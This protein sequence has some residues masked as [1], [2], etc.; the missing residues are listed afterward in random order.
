MGKLSNSIQN[1]LEFFSD[2]NYE[3]LT[4]IGLLKHSPKPPTQ[5]SESAA[6]CVTKAMEIPKNVIYPFLPSK[7]TENKMLLDKPQHTSWN[8]PA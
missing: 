5:T 2:R 3:L 8:A 1:H 4:W 7:E 6:N